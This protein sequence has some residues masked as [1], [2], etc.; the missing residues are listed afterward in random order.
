VTDDP[1][2]AIADR[3]QRDLW[4]YVAD[5]PPDP[6]V[7]G[8]ACALAAQLRLSQLITERDGCSPSH[9]R[10]FIVETDNLAL[11]LER[12]VADPDVLAGSCIAEICDDAS[13]FSRTLLDLMV[14][15]H[16]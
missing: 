4:R 7:M 2:V 12:I 3:L 9:A 1:V 11:D 6:M 15:G 5:A 10:G 8:S 16:A 14:A 13:A